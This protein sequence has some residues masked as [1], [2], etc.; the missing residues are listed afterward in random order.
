[1]AKKITCP[2][3][4]KPVTEPGLCAACK[5]AY[6]KACEGEGVGETTEKED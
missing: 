4:D 2:D 1:M 5:E 3:C 6:A